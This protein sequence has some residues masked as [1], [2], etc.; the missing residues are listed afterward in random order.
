[1]YLNGTSA[2]SVSGSAIF[3]TFNLNSDN[4]AGVTLNNNLSVSGTHTFVNGDIAS[5]A[6]PHYLI[7]QSTASH[8]GASDAAHVTGWVKKI[9]TTDF[10]FPTGNGSYLREIA[11]SN[12]S[13]SMEINGKY[14]GATQNTSSL[15]A[16]LVSINPSEYWTLT[17]VTGGATTA[18]VTLN[19]DNPK[20]AFPNYVL[21]DIRSAQYDVGT[22]SWI[23]TGGTATGMVPTTGSVT[24]TPLNVLGSLSIGSVSFTVPLQFLS[25]AAERK[26]THT[27]LEWRTT[28]EV[29]V[30]QHEVQR[31]Y[32]ARGFAT[33]GYV[34]AHNTM[35][36][37]NY[38][39][40][41][42]DNLQGTAYY[43]IK[44]VDFD[45]KY[46][47]SKVVSVSHTSND[48]ISLKNNPV[49]GSINLLLT[50]TKNNSF[51]YQVLSS[52][53]ALVQQGIAYYGG[54][55][56][57]SIFVHKGISTGSYILVMNDGKKVFAQKIIIE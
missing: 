12:L 15:T 18:Q 10:N 28:N 34:P 56:S 37:D 3:T 55:G 45:G 53:G 43:R 51:S 2:Q 36:D 38:S 22:G 13:T 7:Y 20:V 17:N 39:Y 1:M 24:S 44:S 19:W 30:K 27:L 42:K 9:G 14:Q 25:I 29:N 11:V 23:N 49:K 6:T 35:N 41:D 21:A 47:Y 57:L 8:T 16:P 46:K 33:I 40:I 54:T 5:S 50:S 32:T 31:S 4:N 52:G 26:A 48:V